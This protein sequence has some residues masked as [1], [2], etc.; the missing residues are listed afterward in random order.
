MTWNEV[1]RKTFLVEG[2][3]GSADEIISFIKKTREDAVREVLERVAEDVE[4][5]EKYTGTRFGG[6]MVS[7]VKCEICGC[8]F[9][10]GTTAGGFCDDC[11][12]KEAPY[13]YNMAI[14]EVLAILNKHKNI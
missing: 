3:T 11:I 5:T 9:V 2:K 4:K 14:D 6:A 12:K 8:E 13:F 10:S 1:F 7:R